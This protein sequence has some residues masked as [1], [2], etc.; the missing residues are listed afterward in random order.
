[1]SR[2]ETRVWEADPNAY[3]GRAARRSFRFKAFIPDR[4][5]DSQPAL[6][7]AALAAVS[8][9]ERA[10]LTLNHRAQ[11]HQ[12]RAFSVWFLRAES[13]GSS[14]IEGHQLSQRRLARAEAEAPESRD[15]TA[16]A[17]LGNLRAMESLV[18][19]ADRPATLALPQ[20]LE[21]HASLMRE[22]PAPN[23]A[24]ALRTC[25]NWIGGRGVSPADATFIPPPPEH[26]P[27][28]VE[29]LLRFAGRTDLPPILQAAI[30]HAQF[31]AIH[32]FADGNGRVGRGLIHYVLRRRELAPHFLPPISPVLAGHRGPYLA[33]LNGYAA[34][35]LEEWTDL[36]C[37]ATQR[38][39]TRADRLV[40]DVETLQAAW[41]ERA[42]HP[43]ADSSAEALIRVLPGHP[44]LTVEMAANLVGRS[45]QAANLAL[46]SLEDAQVVKQISAGKWRRAFEAAEVL[47]L[48]NAF[49]HDLAVPDGRA[50]PA[51]QAPTRGPVR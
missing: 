32:P 28:L 24:G 41:R 9:A 31:E 11:A 29:D 20:L 16:K 51:R 13:I 33:G 38:A 36:F 35:R 7:G 17:V 30:A 43:R 5:A 4:I 3:G 48:Y 8:A 26:V 10:V 46:R 45:V 22:T 49:E 27:D 44:V 34:G 37:W 6:S 50:R 12:L 2:Y 42:R 14:W 23:G 19:L 21:V 15:E 18:A 47:S 40:S 1:M 39:T 25:Q